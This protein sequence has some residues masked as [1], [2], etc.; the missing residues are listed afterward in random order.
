[1]NEE[2][3]QFRV[4]L[5]VLVALSILAAMILA[6]G[7]FSSLWTPHYVLAVHFPAAPGIY[8]GTPVK[9]SG[10][11]IGDVQEVRFDQTRGGVVVVVAIQEKYKLRTDSQ[12]AIARG[13]FGDTTIEF[14]PGNA[15]ELLKPG[16][17]LEGHLPPDPMHVVQD[18]QRTLNRTLVS[19]DSTSREWRKVAQNVNALIETNHGR[20]DVIMDRAAEALAKLTQTLETANQTLTAANSLLNDPQTQQNI[21]ATLAALPQLVR[22]THQTIAAA[23]QTLELVS[24]NLRSLNQ[25]TAPLAQ[26]SRDITEKLDRSLSNIEHLSANLQTFTDNLVKGDGSIQ[27]LAS[28]PR[29]YQNLNRS[30]EAL[31]VLLKNLELVVNDLRVFSDKVARH[32]ELLGVA[33]AVKGSS[34]LKQPTDQEL[35]QAQNPLRLLRR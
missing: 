34:G 7:Q 10:V 31:S 8:V 15:S 28:D 14:T 9:M 19:F 26:R 22:E 16:T 5:F 12:V 25:A 20:L 2:K 3:L 17:I 18:V 23:R 11:T 24:A 32:P 27:R 33:G 13:L 6:F 21:R 29:L 30:A 4:G 35:R 1:M